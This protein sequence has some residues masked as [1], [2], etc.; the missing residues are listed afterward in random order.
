MALQKKTPPPAAKAQPKTTPTGRSNPPGPAYQSLPAKQEAKVPATNDAMPDFMKGQSGAGTEALSSS[1]VAIPRIK[2]MQA[3]SPELEQFEDLSPGDFLHNLLEENLGNEIQLVPVYTDLRAILWRPRHEGGGILARSEDMKIWSP[4]N[5]SF[6]VKPIKGADIT[7]EWN[8]SKTVAESRL[9]EWGT[10]N[11]KDPKSQPAG[12]L[13]Y[14]VAMMLPARPDVGPV[15]V[16]MQR[17]GIRVARNFLGKVKLSRAPS[18]GQIYTMS[19]VQEQ[20]PEGPFWNYKFTA[21][22]LVQD[23]TEYNVY[24]DMYEMFKEQGLKIRD[25]EGLQDDAMA[26]A[27]SGK[28]AGPT[29]SKDY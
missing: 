25:E 6:T 10:M 5:V 29:D 16:T 27:G 24:R 9:L 14:N 8:T 19:S 11:P 12:T 4:S 20:G 28:P 23:E 2:L 1:D 3:I 15:V 22:G 21:A 26:N 18:Y 7:V 17:A 13:M